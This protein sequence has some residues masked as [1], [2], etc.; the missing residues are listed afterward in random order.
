MGGFN[1]PSG[2]DLGQAW[3]AS[4]NGAQ[5]PTVRK[6]LI[7]AMMGS[8]PAATMDAP[9]QD[10]IAD[11]LTRHP[12]GLDSA[13]PGS[14]EDLENRAAVAPMRLAQAMQAGAQPQSSHLDQLEQQYNGMQDPAKQPVSLKKKIAMIALGALGGPGVGRAMA[15][16]KQ[17]EEGRYDRTRGSLLTQIEAERRMSEQ[18]SREDERDTAVY[19]RQ[20]E[21]QR[22]QDFRMPPHTMETAQGPLQFD[23]NTRQWSPIMVNGQQA[24]PKAQPKPDLAEQQFFDSPEEAGKTLAQKIA[25]YARVSQKPEQPQRPPQQLGIGPDG[26]VI[27]LKPGIK[28]PQ[29]TQSAAGFEKGASG[30]QSAQDAQN[31]ATE[32]MQNGH[33]TGPGDE[34]LMEKYFEL[35]K[36]SSGFRM[37]QAQIEM[38]TKARDL[39]G[40]LGAKAKHYFTPEAPYFSDEQRKQIVETMGMLQGAKGGGS[41]SNPVK[42]T[43]GGKAQGLPE[44]KTGTGS[45]NKKYVVK[46]GVWVPAQ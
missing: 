11:D 36:P 21:Q 12:Q 7:Q 1:I 17:N 26:T 29:G 14:T 39:M 37:T 9:P 25:D 6:R 20:L 22:E 19:G 23:P 2:D 13:A 10:R 24:G 27:D 16:Q 15:Q 32:Y 33:F 18:N 31:Y 38:L 42:H 8:D 28:V 34:A 41:Q 43:P 40:G 35:A 4:P 46:G 3:G 44:G 45:D 5:D 30:Q